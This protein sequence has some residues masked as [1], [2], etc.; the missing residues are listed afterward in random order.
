MSH[1]LDQGAQ[2]AVCPVSCA[3]TDRALAASIAAIS[4]PTMANKT[5]RFN[6]PL[7]YSRRIG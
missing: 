1:S 2:T 5:M 6:V 7:L 4:A 3:L